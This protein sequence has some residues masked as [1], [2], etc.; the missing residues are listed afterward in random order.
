M[1]G[2]GPVAAGFPKLPRAMAQRLS[3]AAQGL[4]ALLEV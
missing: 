1:V 3:V 2:T 4:A